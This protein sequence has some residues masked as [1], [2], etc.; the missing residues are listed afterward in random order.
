VIPG[1]DLAM[2]FL[3]NGVQVRGEARAC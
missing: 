3:E 2:V 1:A